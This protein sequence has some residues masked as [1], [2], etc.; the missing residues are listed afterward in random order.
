MFREYLEVG[1]LREEGENI[2]QET[3]IFNSLG[4]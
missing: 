1:S 2:V 4:S 3:K